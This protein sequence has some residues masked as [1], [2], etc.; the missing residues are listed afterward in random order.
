MPSKVS[1]PLAF[2]SIVFWT[3]TVAAILSLG[4]IMPS[5]YSYCVKEGLVCIAIAAPLV[6][7][8]P[9]VLSVPNQTCGYFA[10]FALFLTL[11]IRVL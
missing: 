3:Y 6:A 11:S 2:S 7:N 5:L 8:L 10:T 4:E 1:K 9:L